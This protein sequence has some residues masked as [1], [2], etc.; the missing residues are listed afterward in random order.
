MTA[1]FSFSCYS[2]CSSAMAE[3][4]GVNVIDAD[5]TKQ[6][7]FPVSQETGKPRGTTL[8]AMVNIATFSIGLAL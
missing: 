8:I 3:L 4:S 6:K 7:G 1:F 5:V 2:L